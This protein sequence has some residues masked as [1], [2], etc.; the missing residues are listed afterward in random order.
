MSPQQPQQQQQQQETLASTSQVHGQA[1]IDADGDLAQDVDD[2]VGDMETR[3]LVGT[4]IVSAARNAS[5]H[6]SKDPPRPAT[7]S[8]RTGTAILSPAASNST[9]EESPAS[10][11]PDDSWVDLA[12][13]VRSTYSKESFAVGTLF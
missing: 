5:R 2:V 1:T 11:R 12:E 13:E 8:A 6:A 10:R 7:T 9:A 3:P 4:K